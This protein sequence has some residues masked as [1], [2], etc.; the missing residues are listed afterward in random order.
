MLRFEGLA[1]ARADGIPTA[2]LS[3]M[4][5]RGVEVYG[6]GLQLLRQ[7]D[8]ESTRTLANSLVL[9]TVRPTAG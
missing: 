9:S 4:C 8:R 7:F 6:S 2:I 1:I 5:H 3:N